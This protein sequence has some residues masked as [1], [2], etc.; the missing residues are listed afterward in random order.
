MADR[1]D[2]EKY[3][4]QFGRLADELDAILYSVKLPL[5]PQVHI[6]AL[7]GKIRATRDELAGFVI[8]V[9]GENPWDG[10]LLEG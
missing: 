9:S 8:E 1:N 3:I 4:E 5:S 2:V 7:C 10:N 6:D